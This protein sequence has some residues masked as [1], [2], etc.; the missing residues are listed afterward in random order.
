MKMG[1]AVRGE[2]LSL[3]TRVPELHRIPSWKEMYE[4]A[5]SANSSPAR[6]PRNISHLFPSLE[7]F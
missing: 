5:G 1:S 2:S 7:S 4:G 6:P 3:P